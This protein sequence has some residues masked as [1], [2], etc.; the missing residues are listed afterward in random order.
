MFSS[1]IVLLASLQAL[2]ACPF[3]RSLR[4]E[5]GINTYILYILLY[6]Y[7]HPD[8]QG[9]SDV[10][11]VLAA[12]VCLKAPGPLVPTTAGYI[13]AYNQAKAAYLAELGPLVVIPAPP[14]GVIDL[15]IP[16]A[17]RPAFFK[18]ANMAGNTL[19]VT[20]NDAGEF[21]QTTTDKNG[22]DGC[23]STSDPNHGLIE[24]TTFVVSFLQPLWQTMCDKI[25]R[26]DFWAMYILLLLLH[27]YYYY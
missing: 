5:G 25:S 19:R 1:L 2:Y 21:D 12:P 24:T 4:G 11:S 22:P 3:N 27:Y 9:A 10:P 13:T 6:Y 18:Q 7:I 23:L 26:A 17:Q 15:A 8:I 20:F 14:V 16:V